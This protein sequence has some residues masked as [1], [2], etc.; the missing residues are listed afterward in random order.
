MGSEMQIIHY[1][2]IVIS[3]SGIAMLNKT[4][5]NI[6]PSPSVIAPAQSSWS[7]ERGVDCMEEKATC[8][9]GSVTRLMEELNSPRF[10]N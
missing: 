5:V 2:N 10:V 1:E 3:F 8:I 7:W 6:T 4:G 9:S